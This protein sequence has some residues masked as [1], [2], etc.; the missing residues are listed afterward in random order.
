MIEYIQE[1]KFKEAQQHN[2]LSVV[3]VNANSGER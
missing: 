3:A 1:S 2:K